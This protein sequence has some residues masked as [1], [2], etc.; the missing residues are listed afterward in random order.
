MIRACRDLFTPLSLP[1]RSRSLCLP[2]LRTA[3]TLYAQRCQS[4][5]EGGAA[6]RAPGREVIAAL[7]ADRIVQ[8]L[9]S[10]LMRQ[11]G[12]G[13]TPAE[14]SAIAAFLSV[15][16]PTASTPTG[17]ATCPDAGSPARA[18]VPGDWNGWGV[19]FPNE[20]FQR[21]PG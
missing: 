2:A 13:L 21:Q 16:R 19:S 18:A 17:A 6:S 14:R 8:S 12:E 1:D 15:T 7:T 20:R 3:P 5:H 11:Q 10:G 4:C 9:E